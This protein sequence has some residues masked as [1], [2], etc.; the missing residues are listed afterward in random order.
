MGKQG[1][2]CVGPEE[3]SSAFACYSPTNS[4]TNAYCAQLCNEQADCPSGTACS[5]AFG[6]CLGKAS[7]AS[8][9]SCALRVAAPGRGTP[10]PALV[11]TASALFVLRKR[12]RA[13]FLKRVSS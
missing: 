1:D 7:A 3:C 9:S 11:L 2:Q 5:T 10:L 4:A 6:V 12:K 13:S 8:D